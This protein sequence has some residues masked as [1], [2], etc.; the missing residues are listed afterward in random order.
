MNNVHYYLHNLLFMLPIYLMFLGN[1]FSFPVYCSALCD[2]SIILISTYESYMWYEYCYIKLFSLLL[3]KKV[4]LCTNKD[5]T[6]H[7][8]NNLLLKLMP[9]K[10]AT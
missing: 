3:N 4:F 7:I 5:K 2:N 6:Y 9:E 1:I 10:S 8:Y